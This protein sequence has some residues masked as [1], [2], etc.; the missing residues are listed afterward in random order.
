MGVFDQASHYAVKLDPEGFFAWRLPQFTAQFTFLGWLDVST[1]AFP[2]EPNRVCDTAAE[3][4][5][6]D[7]IGAR[8][9]LDIEC[10]SEPDPDM[11]ERLGEYSFRLR[12]EVRHGVGQAGKYQVFGVL[13]NLTGPAQSRT[14]LAGGVRRRRRVTFPG[15]PIYSARRRRRGNFAADCLG[16]ISELRLALDSADAGRSGIG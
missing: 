10:Q 11:L 15:R 7:G 9:I 12:R 6:R 1:I 16:R 14:R 8:R 13:L 3:F 5:P 2:G 4:V